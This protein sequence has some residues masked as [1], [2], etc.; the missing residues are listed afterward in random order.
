MKP[1]ISFGLI[2]SVGM[3][4]LFGSIVLKQ[5]ITIPELLYGFFIGLGIVMIIGSFIKERNVKQS[6]N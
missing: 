5:L 2:R 1:L 4:F 6:D 3:L